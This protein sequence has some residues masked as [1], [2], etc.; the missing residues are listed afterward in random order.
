LIAARAVVASL[1]CH[2]L[3]TDSVSSISAMVALGVVARSVV[4][5]SAW[6]Q[7][8]TL[9]NLPSSP[10]PTQAGNVACVE[11]LLKQGVGLQA[12][13]EPSHLPPATTAPALQR[14]P[15]PPGSQGGA[16]DW[17]VWAGQLPVHP[18]FAAVLGGSLAVVD[19]LVAAGARLDVRDGR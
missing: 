1:P 11:W 6:R 12:L 4:R 9:P 14:Q 10:L 16:V 15:S 3:G 17:E 2:S 13:V 18:L 8:P 7:G 19:V 5:L